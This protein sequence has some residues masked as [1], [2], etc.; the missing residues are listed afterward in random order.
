MPT[1]QTTSAKTGENSCF[2]RGGLRFGHNGACRG[3]LFA[4]KPLNMRV[5][6]LIRTSTPQHAPGRRCPRA[7]HRA[8]VRVVGPACGSSG[9]RASERGQA[10]NGGAGHSFRARGHCGL[11]LL[12]RWPGCLKPS[13]PL[14]AGECVGVKPPSPLRVRN[15]RFYGAFRVQRRWRFQWFLVGGV[16]WCCWFQCRHRV[17]PRARHSSPCPA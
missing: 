4:R 14:L 5:N 9:P 13:S 7:G 1:V 17:A 16:Q 11:A 8:H 15:R 6:P 10:R 12:A 3:V 2:G